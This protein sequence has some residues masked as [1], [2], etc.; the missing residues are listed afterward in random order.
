[1]RFRQARVMGQVEDVK[2]G[3]ARGCHEQ[4]G[5]VKDRR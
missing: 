5:Q 3:Y 2:A 4:T 1:M